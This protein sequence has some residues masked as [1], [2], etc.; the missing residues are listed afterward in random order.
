M[1]DTANTLYLAT[2]MYYRKR[3][4]NDPSDRR[5]LDEAYVNARRRGE[6]IEKDLGLF[7]KDSKTGD[8]SSVRAWHA[9][10]DL[11][12]V[13]Y[14]QVTGG[15]TANLLDLNAG[16]AHSRLS[17][18]QLRNPASV[19]SAYRERLD[20]SVRGVASAAGWGKTSVSE[21]DILNERTT[22]HEEA[23]ENVKTAEP[24]STIVPL[25]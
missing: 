16:P 19:L 24:T 22:P 4:T 10:M 25:N 3:A 11:L 13:R 6:V 12:T 23:Q 21:S 18:E 5:V 14:F 8:E 9:T 17:K 15:V 20:E 2:Q 1:I 7:F